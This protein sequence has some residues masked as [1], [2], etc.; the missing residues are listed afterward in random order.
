MAG[1]SVLGDYFKPQKMTQT[2]SASQSIQA[3]GQHGED[4]FAAWL[5]RNG[6]GYVYISQ[7]QETFATLFHG[8]VKRPDFLVLLD[9][10]GIL[11]VDVKN[12]KASGGVLTLTWDTE[13]SRVLTF[14]RIFRLPVWYAYLQEEEAGETWYWISALKAVEAGERRVNERRGEVFLA[15]DLVHFE[16][17]RSGE[18]LGKLF[19]HRLPGLSKIRAATSS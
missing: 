1:H 5:D 15:I 6:F 12:Y 16:T 10:I 4:R 7:T 18:D 2:I 17:I 9:S 19:T 8:D 3:Q 13:I 11:A 14:E